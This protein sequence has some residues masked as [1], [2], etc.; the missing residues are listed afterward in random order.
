MAR[1]A[2]DTIDRIRDAADILD[3]VAEHVELRRRG[4]NFFGLCPFHAEKTPS[5]SVA[6]DKQIFH[7]FGCG[8][9]G[10]VITFLMEY[11]KISF[12]EA[13][14]SLAQ[15]YGIELKLE[16]DGASK[17][18]FSQMY[19]IHSLATEL[20]RKNLQSDLGKKIRR[21]L[22]DRGLT[23]ETLDRFSVGF[24]SNKWDQLYSAVKSKK[25]SDEV[26]EKCGLFTRSE[27]GTFDRFRS[28]LMF[29]ISNRSGRV[30][31]FGGRDMDGE[32]EAKY[33]N[34]PET[35][36][37]NKSEIL[38]GF[39]TTKDAVRQERCLIVVEGY[40]DLLQLY[41]NGITNIAASSG[42]ALTGQHV[43]QIRKFTD[44]VYL[45]YDG[46]AAGKKAAIN[47]GYNLL[48]GG[49][50]AE[51][52]RLPDDSDPDS[53]V[54]AEGAEPFLTAKENATDL[55]DFHLQNTPHDL[56]KASSRSQVARDIINELVGI[57]D[58]IVRHHTVRKVAEALAV[59]DEV[60]IRMLAQQSRRFGR[61]KP[62]K[63]T[64]EET[65]LFSS[66]ERA[67][68]EIVKLLASDDRE[69]IQLLK[70]HLNRD[71]FSHPVLKSLAEYLLPKAEQ[72]SAGKLSGAIDQFEKESDRKL[73]SKVLFE[74]LSHEDSHRVAV[75]CL[76][77]LEKTPLRERITEHRIRLRE[78]E[79]KGEDSSSTLLEVTELQ[80]RLKELESKRTE[81]LSYS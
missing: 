40:T 62:K 50:T 30:V 2:E 15:R 14:Q 19:D 13:L 74:A 63:D 60:L 54:K 72:E 67:Q 32:S 22:K 36:I 69:V 20:Y 51:I 44:T 28:R 29:P 10:N 27:K 52:I 23:S 46:D 79:R 53:W 24:T 31:A 47:A 59:D 77:A 4:K 25:F 11:E 58:E 5:F 64:D 17:E 37:Y 55:I 57:R 45:A 65:S 34:S 33:L 7:C 42:T 68:V 26:I 61:S 35:P 80:Q 41:Q 73:A 71:T 6:P 21:Y 3:I 18:F 8:A 43:I 70:K 16:R 81:L 9:G 38:Y 66:N 48:R 78:M 76:I 56:S 39:S 1:I 12:T 49:L 75:D